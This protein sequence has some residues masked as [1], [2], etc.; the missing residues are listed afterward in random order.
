MERKVIE[1]NSWIFHF[2]DNLAPD[3]IPELQEISLNSL[4]YKANDDN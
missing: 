4:L 2:P 3:N 1:F